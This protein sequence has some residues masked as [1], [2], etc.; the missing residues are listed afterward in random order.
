MT[1]LVFDIEADGL[2]ATKIWCIVAIDTSTGESRSFGPDQL[3]EGLQ[4][5]QSASKLVGHNIIGYDLPTINR[6]LG[7][8]LSV[9]RKV[10]DTLVLS[11]LF[12]P[13]REGGHGLESW[14]YRLKSPK[15]EHHEYDRFTPEMLKYCE[16]DV[17]LNYKLF[18]QLKIES[19]DFSPDSVF[20]EHETYKIISQQRENGFLLDIKHATCL[21]AQLNDELTE[22]ENEVHKTFTPK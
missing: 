17:Y 10:V 22:A 15:I 9:G 14:G 5:L 13:V 4:Y 1:T 8:D 18:N 3:D 20:L 12:N 6:L 11:R 21:V 16:Q 19:K 2:V 7:A